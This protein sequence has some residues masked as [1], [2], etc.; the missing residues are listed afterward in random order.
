MEAEA[1]SAE[2]HRGDAPILEERIGPFCDR[3]EDEARG[4]SQA[5]GLGLIHQALDCPSGTQKPCEPKRLL[6]MA[7]S[8]A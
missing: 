2:R 8:S 3:T 4:R 1:L 7:F 6:M 5:Y